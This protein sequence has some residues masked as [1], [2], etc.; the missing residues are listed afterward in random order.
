MIPDLRRTRE[1]GECTECCKG[2]LHANIYGR[3]MD[4]GKPCHFLGTSGCTIYSKRPSLCS[5]Y[6]CEWLRDDGTNIPEWIRPDLSKVMI[7]ER[8]WGEKEEHKYW[9]INECGQK[10]DSNILNWIF[11]FSSTHSICVDYQVD[12]RWH[13]LG[14]PEFVDWVCT[15]VHRRV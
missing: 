3:L 6:Q 14:P 9:Q 2:E 12:N 13:Q 1:C 8:T 15:H 7:S 10:I 4:K 11:M 5:S